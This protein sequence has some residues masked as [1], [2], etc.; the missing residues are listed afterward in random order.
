MAIGDSYFEYRARLGTA[1]YS[2]QKLAQQ[3]GITGQ[4]VAL[5]QNLVD[6]L[7]EPFLF[8]VAGEVNAGKSTFLNSLFGADF[9]KADVLPTTDRICLFK[10][11]A[12]DREVEVTP[13]LNEIYRTHRF[14]QDFNIVDTPG[15]NSLEPE[16]QRITERFIPMADLVIF[17][18]PVTNPWGASTWRF[19]ERVHGGWFKNVVFIVQQCD[20]RSAEEVTAIIEHM[21]LTAMQRL[22]REVPIFPISGKQAFLAKTGNLLDADKVLQHSGVPALER[23]I[24]GVVSSAEARRKKLENTLGTA[25]VILGEIRDRIGRATD[26]LDGDKRLL[27]ELD[28]AAEGQKNV[29]EE[30]FEAMFRSLDREYMELGMHGGA[31]LQKRSGIGAS[32]RSLIKAEPAPALIE[33]KMGNSLVSSV[34]EVAGGSLRIL[35]DDLNHLWDRLAGGLQRHFD[36]PLELET[37]TGRPD[38]SSHGEKLLSRMENTAR[39]TINELD[40]PPPLE[41]KFRARAWWLRLFAFCALATLAGTGY[42]AWREMYP[43]A[44]IAAGVFI[45]A[46]IC[47]GIEAQRRAA[48]IH[49]FYGERIESARERFLGSLRKIF[50]TAL[51]GYFTD[52]MKIFQPL[53]RVC[54]E[55]REKYGPQVSDL[56]NLTKTF[57][58]LKRGL[59]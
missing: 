51:D 50:S 23:Y 52:F 43:Q 14:L 32:L 54:D 38:W 1:L 44:L 35:E 11:G 41:K 8:V 45:A 48:A 39:Q 18:F 27:E 25:T 7:K 5:I 17:V 56:Q 2:L 3:T 47:G 53:R 40:L 46:I 29:T 12:K 37:A 24:S 20:L 57:E 42:L 19:L 26:I 58:E 34:R 55:N 22:G 9:C 13:T 49:T 31:F 21:R 15:T 59:D 4:R 10:H 36:T 28:R 6:G 30:K 33:R 16:H